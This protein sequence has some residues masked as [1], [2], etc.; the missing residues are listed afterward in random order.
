MFSR[1]ESYCPRWQQVKKES[2]HRTKDCDVTLGWPKCTKQ[3]R[4]AINASVYS[5][6]IPNPIHSIVIS[7]AN[8]IKK[9]AQY[10][11]YHKIILCK[12][13]IKQ[14]IC[15]N[16]VFLRYLTAIIKCNFLTYKRS[17]TTSQLETKSCSTLKPDLYT[18]MQ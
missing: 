4:I 10:L 7:I 16:Y 17:A 8:M 13:L 18:E 6:T 3:T 14:Y 15:F 1:V 9:R 5:H 12:Y 11:A 2:R